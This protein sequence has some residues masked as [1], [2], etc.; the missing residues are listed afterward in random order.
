MNR[1]SFLAILLGGAVAAGIAAKPSPPLLSVVQLRSPP[2]PSLMM[3]LRNI[4]NGAAG[5]A[6]GMV[7]AGTGAGRL[8]AV[9]V[10]ASA[11]AGIADAAILGG[12]ALAGGCGDKAKL[13]TSRSIRIGGRKRPYS[14]N[15]F[16]WVLGGIATILD[17]SYVA[18]TC[19]L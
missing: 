1:R 18:L 9:A 8:G 15:A 11:T 2:R 16:G 6:G 12:D 19:G 5:E 7:A 4:Q 13:R 3:W 10:A 14:F 17:G